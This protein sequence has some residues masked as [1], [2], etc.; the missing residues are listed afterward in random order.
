MSIVRS[1]GTIDTGEIIAQSECKTKMKSNG[2]TNHCMGNS[3][4]IQVRFI[5]DKAGHGSGAET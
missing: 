4:G 3:L 2:R 1:L 5:G